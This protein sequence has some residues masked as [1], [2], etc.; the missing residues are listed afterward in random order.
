MSNIV[1]KHEMLNEFWKTVP[2]WKNYFRKICWKSLKNQSEVC[3][4]WLNFRVSLTNFPSNDWSWNGK[5]LGQ[6]YESFLK[7]REFNF[8]LLNEV[9]MHMHSM[10]YDLIKWRIEFDLNFNAFQPISLL[11]KPIFSS[12]FRPPLDSIKTQL[13]ETDPSPL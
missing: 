3:V 6:I 9:A 11:L 8:L 1:A 10:H 7:V 4:H 13:Y 5:S 12:L 2:I